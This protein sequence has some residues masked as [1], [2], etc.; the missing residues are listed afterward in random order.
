MALEQIQEDMR[1]LAGTLPHRG[2]NTEEELAAATYI[3]DRFGEY[4]VNRNIEELHA[5]ESQGVLFAAYYLEFLIVTLLALWRP[6]VAFFYGLLVFVA[7]LAEFTGYRVLSRF[8]PKYQTQNV[9]ARILGLNPKKHFIITAHYD[10][11]KA[12]A[13]SHPSALA[14][15][16]PAHYLVMF[17]MVLILLSCAAQTMGVFSAV[18]FPINIAVRWLAL[19]YLI[20]AAG[21]LFFSEISGEHVRGAINNASGAA[22]LLELAERFTKTPMENA[23][24]WLVATGSK[25]SWLSGMR[26]LVKSGELDKASTYILN[27]DHVGAGALRYS[28]GEGMLAFFPASR[29]M[30]EAAKNVSPA[31]AATPIKLRGMPTETII[32][33]A[34]GYRAMGICATGLDDEFMHWN[35]PSDSLDKVDYSVVQEAAHF[36]ETICRELGSE[37]DKKRSKES[38]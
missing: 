29:D 6:S 1:Y 35:A 31:F 33:L 13:L 5:S 38:D 27:I 20:F 23:D 15:L 36:A 19:A 18:E 10:T 2:S 11:G 7:Y 8:L 28:T 3:Y 25:G 24:V 22:V 34:R 4:T 16:R 37:S 21:A 26:H 30:L 14:W 9:T 32:P 12:T 17:S